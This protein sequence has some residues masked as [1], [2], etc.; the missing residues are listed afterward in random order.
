[1]KQIT[2]SLL[3]L[4]SIATGW[5]Q[6][7][8][9]TYEPTLNWPYLLDDFYDGT[10]I[11]GTDSVCKTRLNIHLRSEA[12]YCIDSEGKIARVIF[13]NMSAII[14]SNNLYRFVDG[15]PMKQLHAEGD[16]LLMDYTYIDFEQMKA[17][18]TQGMALYARAYSETSMQANL[19]N[20]IDLKELHMKGEFN[21]S[22]NEMRNTWY[23]G[24][25]L[26]VRNVC[27]FI[28]HGKT[29]RAIST[30]CN[31]HLDKAAQKKLKQLVKSKKLKWKNREDLV[32]ILKFMK[33][34]MK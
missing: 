27:Y 23:D 16:A 15:K 4:L 2:L 18:Y 6:T 17:G 34:E 26:P 1:M 31:A 24:D 25:K 10:I 28:V 5:A 21:E 14:I 22:Y 19:N 9:G 3:L 33:K 13:P 8:R 32:T 12:L 7:G 29:F 11:I 30:E 20:H